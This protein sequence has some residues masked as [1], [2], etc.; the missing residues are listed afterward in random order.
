MNTPAHDRPTRAI[1]SADGHRFELIECGVPTPTRTLLLLPGL[2]IPARQYI[3]F[4]EA[5]AAHG[6]HSLIHE[7]R[8]LGSSSV[9]ASRR[10]DWGYRELLTLDLPASIAAA[11]AVAGDAPVWIAGHSLGGQLALLTAAGLPGRM[12][13][14]TLIA[15]GLPWIRAFSGAMRWKLGLVFALFPTLAR[16]RGHFPGRRLGFGGNE[17]RG[18]I[19]DWVRT[20]RTGHYDLP[21]LETPV[22]DRLATLEVPILACL[23]A[24][25]HWVPKQSLHLLTAKTPEA[26]VT[27]CEFDAA[28]LGAPADH[29]G[30]M[31][32]PAK[33]AHRMVAWMAAQHQR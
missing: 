27:V 15:S 11:S 5:L 33:V 2:G 26:P 29:F 1:T 14:V 3:A 22:E 23:M 7:W 13:G 21:G 16:L 9:R 10:C 24:D 32:S 20:G 8:G 31:R 18:V 28:T 6:I 30:W 17:S 19:Q 25:D 4:G 12:A